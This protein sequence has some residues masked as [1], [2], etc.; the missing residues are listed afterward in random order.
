MSINISAGNLHD[1]AFIEQLTD[2]VASAK[3]SPSRLILEVT[4]TAAMEDREVAFRAL[5]ALHEAGFKLSIDDFGTGYSSLQY[6]DDLPV[7]EVKIDRSFVQKMEGEDTDDTII[8]AT[9]TIGHELGFKVLAEGVET[10]EI[11]DCLAGKG[12]DLAQG[13]YFAKPQASD[14]ILRWLA[15]YQKNH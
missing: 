3:V 15:D 10:A 14:D 6:L 4:E 9:I 1:A 7:D 5:M 11:R 2:I 12:C 8:K 13:Y